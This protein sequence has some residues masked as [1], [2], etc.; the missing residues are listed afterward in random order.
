MAVQQQMNWSFWPL[1]INNGVS[2]AIAGSTGS[3]KTTDLAYLISCIN[4][5]KRI[6]TIE[7]TRELNIA[8]YE[9]GKMTNRVVQTLTKNGPN[10]ITMVIC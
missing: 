6:Y 1:C 8:K 2:I 7:D 5:N 3:G 9:N 10:P 4:N